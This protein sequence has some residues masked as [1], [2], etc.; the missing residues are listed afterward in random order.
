MD[1]LILLNAIKTEEWTHSTESLF[2]DFYWRCT[3]AVALASAALTLFASVKPTSSS[4][5]P[6]AAVKEYPCTIPITLIGNVP[7]VPNCSVP[8]YQHAASLPKISSSWTGPLETTW[9]ITPLIAWPTHTGFPGERHCPK[10]TGKVQVMPLL[11]SFSCA[12]WQSLQAAG[13]RVLCRSTL[14]PVLWDWHIGMFSQ[15]MDFLS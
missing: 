7:W 15:P 2:L 3:Y 5:W 13:S 10:A 8:C 9:S 14:G 11:R 4:A 6:R 1:F 12:Q